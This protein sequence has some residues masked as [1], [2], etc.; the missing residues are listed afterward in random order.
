[1]LRIL[2]PSP[3][4]VVS[5]WRDSAFLF[6]DVSFLMIPHLFQLLFRFILDASYSLILSIHS[7]CPYFLQIVDYF[8]K[9]QE[10]HETNGHRG[11][12]VHIQCCEG[13]HID[14][15]VNM[16]TVQSHPQFIDGEENILKGSAVSTI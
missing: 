16:H 12:E 7:Y 4:F 8:S 6:S 13:L 1:M 5:V 10:C 3:F 14:K 9:G 2:F 11:S 15:I